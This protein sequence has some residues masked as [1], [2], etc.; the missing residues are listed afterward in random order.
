MSKVNAQRGQ[1]AI[2]KLKDKLRITG[3]LYHHFRSTSVVASIEACSR[4]YG[5]GRFNYRAVVH[6]YKV[7]ISVYSQWRIWRILIF[8]CSVADSVGKSSSSS[9]SYS[10][11]LGQG[12]VWRSLSTRW[13]T[14][15][16]RKRRG[17]FSIRY[18]TI[19]FLARTL[20]L[21]VHY[22]IPDEIID[23]SDVIRVGLNLMFILF[24]CFT[25]VV[26]PILFNPVYIFFSLWLNASYRGSVSV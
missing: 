13:W 17:N 19:S 16:M 23:Q 4:H 8:F 10:H 18:A 7:Y 26:Y 2:W 21:G 6:S 11:Y 24:I 12:P 9:C 1:Y 14:L 3:H 25:N 20:P 5:G 15:A 22:R